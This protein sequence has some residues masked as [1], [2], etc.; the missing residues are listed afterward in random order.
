MGWALALALLSAG[1]LNISGRVPYGG[2]LALVGLAPLLWA[3]L[4]ESKWWR[5]ALLGYVA[6][7]G[8]MTAAF[9]GALVAEP[10]S[11]P[12]LVLSQ[13]VWYAIAGMTFVLAKRSLNSMIATA[14]FPFMWVGAEFISAQ[15]WIWG[16]AANGLSR[17]GYTQ[18]D[19]VFSGSAVWSSISGVSLIVVLV[20]VAVVYLARERQWLPAVLALL[21]PACSLVPVQW[22][23]TTG[24]ALHT[25]AVQGSVTTREIVFGRFDDVAARE[26]L[27]PYRQLTLRA[28]E[29]EPD[30]IIWPETILPQPIADNQVPSYVQQALE[31]AAMAL[32]GGISNRG[33]RTFNSVFIWDGALTEVYRKRS[34]IPVIESHYA[35]GIA[36]PPV[37]V[38]EADVGLGICLDTLYPSF[39][40]DSVLR[41]ADALVFVTNDNFALGTVTPELHFR[42]S[43]FRAIETGR[44]M[45]YVGQSGPT[46]FVSYTGETISKTEMGQVVALQGVL[47]GRTGQTPFVRFGDYI[48][49]LAAL[50]TGFTIAFGVGDRWLARSRKSRA[51]DEA[52][53]PAAAARQ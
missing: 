8:L 31:P 41:G 19:T 1:I 10:W 24:S 14:L 25:I 49:A 53:N 6:S 28:A 13:S 50:L 7:L 20:S 11:Y 32:V 30:L 38:N 34:L 15:R 3:L 22:T 48:G 35:P 43:T 51:G 27:D 29:R 9:E 26:M 44:P 40:R 5:G 46:A 4:G 2:Y 39:S 36:V 45:A 37:P 16:D 42:V 33:G 52:S 12:I 47:E 21:V 18:Y 17:I 23:Q